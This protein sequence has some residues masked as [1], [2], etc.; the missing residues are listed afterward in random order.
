MTYLNITETIVVETD[1]MVFC[2]LTEKIKKHFDI[3]NIDSLL[4]QK[5]VIECCYIKKIYLETFIN[6]TLRLYSDDSILDDIKKIY[7]QM[8]EG[9]ICDMTIND[10]I[11]NGVY[12]GL[13]KN[14][15]ME[16]KNIKIEELSYILNDNSYFDPNFSILHEL[17]TGDL[18]DNEIHIE[19][20]E[21]KKIYY[22]DNMP[23]FKLNG[24]LIKCNCIH[25]QGHKKGLIPEV[26]KICYSNKI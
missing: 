21:M 12:N 9:G 24:N 26:Y 19:L 5:C 25:F 15:N 14:L 22:I 8:S 16:K 10:Y 23:Y 2:D 18:F 1:V 4:S 13:F 11:H 6:T 20:G 17:I 3:E 7:S